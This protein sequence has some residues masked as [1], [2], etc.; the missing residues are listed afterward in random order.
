MLW[1]ERAV[2][3]RIEQVA[4]DQN[5]L[6][7]VARPEEVV[8]LVAAEHLRAGHLPAT[9]LLG[10][11]VRGPE[12]AA[13]PAAQ[14]QP[15][16]EPEAGARPQPDSEQLPALPV[17]DGRGAGTAAPEAVP[18]AGSIVPTAPTSS[19]ESTPI[20]FASGP[21]AASGAEAVL[22]GS[23]EE[24]PESSSSP[25]PGSAGE[26]DDRLGSESEEPDVLFAPPARRVGLDPIHG[27]PTI[28][29]SGGSRRSSALRAI[30]RAVSRLPHN[31]GD[32][33]L[34][35]V[36]VSVTE[37][38]SDK[39]PESRR[40]D[41]VSRLEAAVRDRLD[42]LATPARVSVRDRVEQRASGRTPVRGGYSAQPGPSSLRGEPPVVAPL[43][44]AAPGAVE[45]FG[46]ASG[47]EAELHR[48]RV[49]LPRGA[50]V[51]EFG[52]I[53]EL[54][55]LL[56]ITLDKAGGVPVPEIVTKPA[57]GLVR[58]PA[59]GRAERS[60]V[61]AAVNDVMFR[62]RHARPGARI[63]QIFPESAGYVVDPLAE[64]LP[65]RINEAGYATLVH[66]TATAPT[67][68]LVAFIEHVRGRMRR[69]SPPV[70]I[71]HADAGD[72]LA[73]GAWARQDFA[74]WLSQY[75][76]WADAANPWDGDELEGALA[77]GYT[78]V[79]A[80]VRGATLDWTQ[81]PKD[82]TAVASRDSL[83]AVRSSLGEGP[84]AYLEDR[85]RSIA[86]RFAETVGRGG[87]V[88]DLPLTMSR[89]PLRATVG[90]YLDNLLLH[91]PERF[92]S[93]YEAL[94]IRTDFRTLDA[95]PDRQGRALI[96]PAVVRLEARSYA[97]TEQTPQTIARDS[98]TLAVLSLN[99][100]NEARLD[101]GLP[102][103]GRP[104]AP[105]QP[106]FLFAPPATTAP[107]VRP[108]GNTVPAEPAPAPAP[109]PT[110]LP[111]AL[112]ET[113]ARLVA[114]D[115]DARAREL[116]SLP[117]RDRELLATDPGFVEQARAGL[118]VE[119][120]T[121][122]AARLLVVVPDGVEQPDAAREEAEAL[123]AD[124][125]ADPQITV[126]LL[127]G[128]SRLV[129]VPRNR[130]MT[131][132]DEFAELRGRHHSG[133]GRSLDA[134]RGLYYRRRMVGVG[135]EN[136]LG[137]TTDLL[138]DDA[139]SLARRR[140]HAIESLLSAEDRQLI[141]DVYEVK[142][143]ANPPAQWPDGPGP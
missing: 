79:A 17:P 18:P 141:V 24:S 54:P 100:Y 71:A 92:V 107:S 14:P 34:R 81:R 80:T 133:E 28:S 103:V 37:W 33:D 142:A 72:G 30:D 94:G 99:L 55:G 121:A 74:R 88:L 12:I 108:A 58:G 125:L 25:V 114:M 15:R 85:A 111:P 75:P 11:L 6:G 44:S 131:S 134:A 32:E 8:E 67:S 63:G 20:G 16:P 62:L 26:G 38:K 124:M 51:E 42:Q 97:S 105:A 46:P 22:P 45:G 104:L 98:D 36:L 90:Q 106:D 143:A 50:E 13:Q 7:V 57:R 128:G 10:S 41:A 78:Q 59:D 66:H 87:S 39:T 101:R 23:S 68:R 129:V 116:A 53:V 9:A 5:P 89:G 35:R 139:Y 109:S 2:F 65:V 31:A 21:V 61:D 1:A 29:A 120:F 43:V 96:V 4:P 86:A 102:P 73:F 138:G 122:V 123:V 113:A 3:D 117:Q 137:E 140:A 110:P 56:T 60:E 127:T 115:A 27:W 47:L 130:P 126:A 49:E 132:L 40:W 64:D 112:V 135:E 77:L 82:L 119:D 19:A 83:A 118:S 93:Q 91:G 69:E 136:L 52:D 76:R 95:N 48:Y 70:Q 84:R